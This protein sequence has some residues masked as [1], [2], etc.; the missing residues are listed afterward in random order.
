[1]ARTF[2]FTLTG[3]QET[4]PVATT[5][6]GAGTVVWDQAA[7]AA[8]YEVT[9]AGLDFGP[10]L[11]MDPQTAET[12]DDVTGMHVHAAPRGAPGPVAFGQIG[13]AQDADDLSIAS[14][15][16]GSWTVRGAW[17]TTDPAN[18]PIAGFAD[19]LTAA[20]AGSDVPLY[21]NV[22]TVAFPAG[23]VRGQWV[24][25][26]GEPA[27]PV[28]TVAEFIGAAHWTYGR[29][30]GNLP[31][32][33]VPF[34]VDGRHLALEVTEHGFYGAAF[35]TPIDQVVV[36]FEGTFLSALPEDPE[37]VLAQI[38]ADLQLYFGRAPAALADALGFTR[39][40]LAAAEARGIAA[41]DVFVTGHSLG[42]AEAAYVAAQLG[43]AG[44]T[45]GAPG[46][47]AAAIPQGAASRLVNYVEYGDPVGNYSAN[48]NRLDGF[49][50]SD[51]ILR[52]GA[53]TYLGDAAVE[54]AALEFA[55]ALFGPGATAQD[56]LE[57]LGL[58]A[59]LAAEFHVL[60]AY[61]ADLGVP[62][63]GRSADGAPAGDAAGLQAPGG[64]ASALLDAAPL[65]A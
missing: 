11:G 20:A 15:P 45:F 55:G 10:L 60:T 5:A 46:I 7:G 24:A 12:A 44:A 63:G 48:P 50:F 29:D 31:A 30:Y 52:F 62:L 3:D 61:A 26:A 35:L 64:L 42:G 56:R 33:L 65:F 2:S 34:E 23:E 53:P 1:M 18:L 22:H 47:P 13:P 59:G 6:G 39:G 14:N 32:D 37:F 27:A 16:D 8:A 40:V 38:A 17:E 51:Q 49:L 57:G 28:P 19:V 21:F 36:A 9:V 58:L 4:P 41:G 25:E 43:L 54:G